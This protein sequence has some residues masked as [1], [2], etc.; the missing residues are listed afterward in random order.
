[1][2]NKGYNTKKFISIIGFIVFVIIIVFYF[3]LYD[4]KNVKRLVSSYGKAAPF[5]FL[6][7]CTIRPILLLPIGLFSVLG[8]ILFGTILGTVY[9]VVGGTIGSIIAYYMARYWGRDWIEGL[10]NGKIKKIDKKCE[11]KGFIVTFLMRVIPIL[12][13][14]VVSYICGLSNIKI[15]E[16][17]VGTFLGIIPGTFV[18]SYFGSSLDNIYSKQFI[19]SVL[20]LILL[21]ILPFI[22]KK[23]N[24]STKN[25]GIEVNELE[26]NIDL[27]KKDDKIINNEGE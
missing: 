21:S 8:G 14:D 23:F 16:Y 27:S 26:E 25:F 13:C 4:L 1:M 7:L 17:I 19:L 3:R 15:W 12:P 6:I 2:I 10:L 11:E 22:I 9:T 18:Y 5:I 24:V 20:F